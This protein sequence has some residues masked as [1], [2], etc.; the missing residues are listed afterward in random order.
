MLMMYLS[1]I[2]SP[3]DK[4]RFEEIYYKYRKLMFVCA[5]EILNNNENA[6]DAVQ[7]AFIKIA[8]NIRKVP[9]TNNEIKTFVVIVVKNTAID[10]YRKEKRRNHT[11]WEDV[12]YSYSIDIEKTIEMKEKIEKIEAAIASLPEIYRVVFGLKFGMKYSN[13]DIARILEISETTL[14]QRIYKGRKLLNEIM[15]KI[16]GSKDGEMGNN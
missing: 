5:K 14:R 10:I 6:E 1:L 2:D 7:E 12:E 3:E 16:E 15:R 8:R 4:S 11:N 9:K 13:K